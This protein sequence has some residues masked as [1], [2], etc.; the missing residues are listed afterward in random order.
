MIEQDARAVWRVFCWGEFVF[1]L[2]RAILRLARQLKSQQSL[3]RA[4]TRVVRVLGSRVLC[5]DFYFG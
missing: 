2:G 3:Q 4:Q 1:L 5:R